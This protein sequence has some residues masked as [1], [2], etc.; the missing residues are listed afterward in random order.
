MEREPNSRRFWRLNTIAA[1]RSS[2]RCE[3]EAL[4][5][6]DFAAI[7][8]DNAE[9]VELEAREK[10][11]RDRAARV[12]NLP[13]A[14]PVKDITR[15]T[16]QKRADELEREACRLA[17]HMTALLS[18]EGNSAGRLDKLQRVNDQAHR[19]ADRRYWASLKPNEPKSP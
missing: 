14:S 15:N 11:V 9:L 6:E 10:A 8:A 12:S 16:E 17:S 19:R 13:K 3:G 7:R 5:P 4:D 1:L 18:R 2:K